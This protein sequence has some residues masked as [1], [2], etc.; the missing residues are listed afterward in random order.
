LFA[1]AAFAASPDRE[2]EVVQRFTVSAQATSSLELIALVPRSI[3]GRQDVLRQAYSVEPARIDEVGENRYAVFEWAEPAA[4]LVV[5][6]RTRL[7][8]IDADLT[9]VNAAPEGAVLADAA[10]WLADE[11]FLEVGNRKI[12]KLARNLGDDPVRRAFERVVDR[13]DPEDPHGED[14][15]AVAALRDGAGD[16]TEYA[17]LLVAVLRA[18]GVPARVVEGYAASWHST[19]KHDWVEVWVAGRGW[20]TLDPI[21]AD[22]APARF[23]DLPVRYVRLS[24]VRNDEALKGFHYY[25]YRFRGGSASV[26]AAVEVDDG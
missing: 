25:R 16:C 15:G 14:R 22:G 6:A 1:G 20:A 3:A 2:V 7:R 11:R 23:A 26:D 10:V 4:E 19:P 18:A 5:E 9:V 24:A 13:T 8:L 21:Y 17:D 12:G